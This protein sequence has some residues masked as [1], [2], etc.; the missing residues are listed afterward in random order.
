MRR[1]D[2]NWR[3]EPNDQQKKKYIQVFVGY[4]LTL[5][6]ESRQKLE[7]VPLVLRLDARFKM[8]TV[9][10]TEGGLLLNVYLHVKK[11]LVVGFLRHH[12]KIVDI[13]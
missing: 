12:F 1:C 2:V 7:I 8:S 9:L 10:A 3:N 13:L 4:V 11:V 5:S 6:T